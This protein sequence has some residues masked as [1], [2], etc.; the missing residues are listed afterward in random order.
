[1]GFEVS[2]KK[3]D[4]AEGERRKSGKNILGFLMFAGY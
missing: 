1:V 2:K 3:V 4:L